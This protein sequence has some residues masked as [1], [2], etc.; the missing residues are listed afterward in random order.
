MRENHFSKAKGLPMDA[1]HF[2]KQAY[3]LF[4]KAIITAELSGKLLCH[5]KDL[6]IRHNAKLVCCKADC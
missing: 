2:F 5:P 1:L 3:F 6:L 4:S